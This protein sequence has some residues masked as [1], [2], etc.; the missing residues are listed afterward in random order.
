MFLTSLLVRYVVK[1]ER[2]SV[3]CQWSIA[4]E[5]V[6]RSGIYIGISYRAPYQSLDPTE[7]DTYGHVI[8]A[9]MGRHGGRPMTTSVDSIYWDESYN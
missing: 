7:A 8:L 6:T 5:I 9:V 3:I 4:Q 2:E 1:K